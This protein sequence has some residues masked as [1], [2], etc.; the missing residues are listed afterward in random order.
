MDKFIKAVYMDILKRG[1]VLSI[2]DNKIY[3]H[4]PKHPIAQLLLNQ[5]RLKQIIRKDLSEI[6]K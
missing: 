3:G 5:T 2:K 4:S 6:I 1:L